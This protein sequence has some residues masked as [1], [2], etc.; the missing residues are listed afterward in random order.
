MLESVQRD[1]CGSEIAA[2]QGHFLSIF[3]GKNK[4]KNKIETH[5]GDKVKR[6][7]EK[8]IYMPVYLRIYTVSL[9]ASVLLCTISYI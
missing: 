8:K 1:V 9:L 5:C 2:N 6:D 7:E 3:F 4:N